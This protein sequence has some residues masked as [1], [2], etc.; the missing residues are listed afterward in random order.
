[1]QFRVT[2]DLNYNVNRVVDTIA[3]H[4]FVFLYIK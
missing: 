1:M 4:D 2:H 3:E